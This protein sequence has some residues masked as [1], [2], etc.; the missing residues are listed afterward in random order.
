M[1]DVTN[2][3]TLSVTSFFFYNFKN[4]L[5]KFSSK[6]LRSDSAEID[7]VLQAGLHI[8]HVDTEEGNGHDR[9]QRSDSRDGDASI[10]ELWSIFI[11]R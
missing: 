11:S 2:V 9:C 1:N 7:L 4:C 10:T 5:S 6:R 8:L 3:A